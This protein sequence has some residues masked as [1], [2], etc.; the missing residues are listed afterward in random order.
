MPPRPLIIDTDPGKDDAVAIL[1]ALSSP[2]DFDVLM[3]SAAAGNVDLALTTANLRRLCDAAGRPDL[4]LHAGC[5]GPLLQR[6]EMVPHIHG[7]DG[8]A[9]AGLPPPAMPLNPLHAVPAIIEAVRASPEKVTFC[10]IGPLTNLGV[11]I[12]MAPDIV[13]RLA[14]IVVMGGSF[15]TGNITPYASFNIYSDPHAARIVFDCGASVTMVG[16]DVTRKT[17]PTPEWCAALKAKDTPA[18]HVVAGLWAEPTAFMNDAC[19][20]AHLLDPSLFRTELCR[21]EIDI[22]DPVELGRTRRLEGGAPNVKAAMDIDVDGFFSLLMDR[23]SR[24]PS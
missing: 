13:E 1:L 3:M 10:C 21:V 12:V 23:L 2:E 11:A 8:L 16:L 4:A 24:A 9:G 5:P 15:T 14:E 7:E 18:A 17:M 6:L 20:I 22:T 19:V